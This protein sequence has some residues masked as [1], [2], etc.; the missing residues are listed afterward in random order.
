[1]NGG[2][3]SHNNSCECKKGYAGEV[4]EE[5]L[6]DRCGGLVVCLNNASCVYDGESTFTYAERLS[7]LV[8]GCFSVAMLQLFYSS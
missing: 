2:V 5:K 1:M 6:S 3:C 7:R 8:Q 4:C